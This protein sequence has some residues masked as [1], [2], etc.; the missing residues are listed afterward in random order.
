MFDEIKNGQILKCSDGPGCQYRYA[1][2]IDREETRWGE[3]LMI[4]VIRRTDGE[5]CGQIEK[6]GSVRNADEL[7]IGWKVM[8]DQETSVFERLHA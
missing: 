8:N 4:R 5:Q 3:V 1:Q 2:V 7:G 6:T